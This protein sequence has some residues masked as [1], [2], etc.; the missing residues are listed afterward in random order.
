MTN[1]TLGEQIKALHELVSTQFTGINGRLDKINGKVQKHD[2]NI[3]DLQMLIEKNTGIYKEDKANHVVNC[4][5]TKRLEKIEETVADLRF[6]FKYPKIFI[7][8]IVILVVISLTNLY[9]NQEM[10]KDVT[11]IKPAIELLK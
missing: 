2:D 11:S 6:I 4:P 7:A 3:H 5:Q 8:G 9:K 10:I 1:E